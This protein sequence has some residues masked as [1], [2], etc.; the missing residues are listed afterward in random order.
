[1]KQIKRF[2]W[3]LI[4][5]ILITPVVIN[6]FFLSPL[7]L[8]SNLG[9][10]EWLTFW[11]SYIGGGIGGIGTLIAVFFTIQYYEKQNERSRRAV[12]NLDN[13]NRINVMLDKITNREAI[14]SSYYSYSSMFSDC[15][16]LIEEYN[17]LLGRLVAYYSNN[18]INMFIDLLYIKD[19]DGELL[20]NNLLNYYKIP[21]NVKEYAFIVSKHALYENAT[22]LIL[23]DTRLAHIIEKEAGGSYGMWHQFIHHLEGDYQKHIKD[24]LN[25]FFVIIPQIILKLEDIKQ[26]MN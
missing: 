14:P 20:Q 16:D 7:T 21:N 10:E 4:T 13:T 9:N 18:F 12:I 19:E 22:E 1:M 17:I 15:K 8:P 5:I 23:A 11:G 26:K 25:R 6:G 24:D 3:I 2:I